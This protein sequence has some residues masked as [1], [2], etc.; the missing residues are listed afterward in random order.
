MKLISHH[1]TRLLATAAA[2][3]IMALSATAGSAA[4]IAGLQD[5]TTIVW[6][7]TDK[8]AVTGSVPLAGGATLVGIDVRPAD[9][10]LYGLTPT[11]TIVT[12]DPMTGKWEKKSELSVALPKGVSFIVD[13]N[14]VADRL[15]VMASDGTSLRINVDDG[16]AVV[17]GTLKYAEADKAKGTTPRVMAGAY[18]NSIAGSKATTLYNLDLAAGTVVRQMP[19]NDGI[20]NTIGGLGIKIDGPVA[21]DIW[22]DAK[23]GN[24]AWLL[25]GG[26]LHSV[27]VE[28]GAAKAVAVIAG[29]KGNIIDMAILP[30]K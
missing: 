25:A 16:K 15:R 30:T 5:G 19:P 9:G 7:D 1:T 8:K 3:S 23:G 27:D 12:I 28:T 20:L 21:F 26:S 13:F 4:T 24:A 29:L 17:D 18:T 6:I 14:P 22:S 2:L 10:V 11:G